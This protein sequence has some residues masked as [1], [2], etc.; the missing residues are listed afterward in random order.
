MRTASNCHN[1]ARA[2]QTGHRRSLLSRME[3]G[4]E[5][6]PIPCV[7][8]PSTSQCIVQ[9]LHRKYEGHESSAL[10]GRQNSVIDSVRLMHT[11]ESDLKFRARET[12]GFPLEE[13]P[14]IV[15]AAQYLL[16]L[17]SSDSG[18][19]N[20]IAPSVEPGFCGQ[21]APGTNTFALRGPYLPRSTCAPTP[22][23]IGRYSHKLIRE[24]S[25]D[26][27]CLGRD[28]R[29]Q[30]RPPGGYVAISHV[31]SHGWQGTSEDGIC[32]RLLDL[33]IDTAESFQCSWIWLDIALISGLPQFR[34][35]SV[36]AIPQVFRGAKKTLVF[37]R[38]LLSMDCHGI[39]DYE[40]CL[41]IH[42][43][44]WKT[45]VWTMSESK[46]SAQLM[47]LWS[48]KHKELGP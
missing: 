16:D 1:L 47:F 37:D 39:S 22:I 26:V 42:V 45:R 14:H 32:S 21:C 27:L 10:V 43:S 29:L 3:S 7:T 18:N 36:N 25:D 13:A 19:A 33:L 41:S 20:S 34:S 31:W 6:P 11:F 35:R 46:T 15:K 17:E 40:M 28:G 48:N 38:L 2:L 8:N 4:C 5:H 9:T 30:Y 12:A 23:D 44:D 24:G